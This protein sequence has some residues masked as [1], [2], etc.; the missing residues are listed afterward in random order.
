[1][2]NTISAYDSSL[3][4]NGF[5]TDRMREVFSGCLHNRRYARRLLPADR[6][7]VARCVD[8]EVALASECE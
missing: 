7:Y 2:N 5:T 4:R 6:A 3:F 1:M 8:A